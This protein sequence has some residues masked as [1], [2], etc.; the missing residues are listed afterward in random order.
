MGMKIWIAIHVKKTVVKAVGK[1]ME[2]QHD[3]SLNYLFNIKRLDIICMYIVIQYF[4]EQLSY[5]M[6]CRVLDLHRSRQHIM[7]AVV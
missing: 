4:W 5:C 7:R 1:Y 2:F 6:Y 3:V